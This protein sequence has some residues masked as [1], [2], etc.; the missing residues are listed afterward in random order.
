MQNQFKTIYDKH[1]LDIGVFFL[2]AL[3]VGSGLL[4]LKTPGKDENKIEISGANGGEADAPLENAT[5]SVKEDNEK[6]VNINTAD[7]KELDGLP[8]IGEKTAEKIISYREETGPFGTLEDIKKVAGIGES[9]FA[10]LKE[11]IVVQ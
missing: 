1:W 8:G 3:L 6:L 2:I 4:L 5:V 11:L 9:K 7:A 10:E